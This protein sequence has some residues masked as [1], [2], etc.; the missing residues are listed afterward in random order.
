MRWDT[1]PVFFTFLVAVGSAWWLQMDVS[2]SRPAIA[3]AAPLH[4]DHR[5]I[6]PTVGANPPP[7][8]VTATAP[9][10]DL[11][12]SLRKRHLRLPLDGVALKSMEGQF[13]QTRDGGR[14]GHEAIDLLAPRHTPIRAVEDGTIAK[15][16]VSKAGGTTV[17]QFD[18]SGRV[19]YYYAH[20]ERYA[21][22][23]KEGQDVDAGDVIGYVGTSG[24]APKNTPHLH[25]AIFELTAERQWWKGKP[26]D[27]FEVYRD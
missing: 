16:F 12:K 24:N 25:F 21:D 4:D 9:D 22:D 19:C 20:L 6:P 11:I 15:L 17:Y 26:L 10:T 2:E 8:R 7:L 5:E 1:L 18:E 14:R 13:R 23:L 3:V 27:P